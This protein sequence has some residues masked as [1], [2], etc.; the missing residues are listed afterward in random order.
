MMFAMKRSVLLIVAGISLMV[1]MNVNGQTVPANIKTPDAILQDFMNKRFGMF[2][3]WGPATLRGGDISWSRNREVAQTDYDSLYKEF[4]PVLFNADAWVK[5][6]SD[7]GMKYLTITAKHHDGFCLW[8]SKYTTH[9]IANTPYKKDIVKQLNDACK[10]Y[11]IKFCIYYTVLDWYDANYPLHNDG[12]KTPD[13]KADMGKFVQYMKN[14]LKELITS[15]HPYMLWFDGNWET[16]WTQDMAVD[17]YTY[18]KKLDAKVIINN[19]LGKATHKE[20]TPQTVGDYATPEQEIGKINMK[21]PW[22]SCIT[23][24]TQWS[25]KPND[26]MKSTAECIRIL[27]RTAGGNGNLLLNFSPMPDGRLEARQVERLEE[28]GSWMKKNGAA[29]YGTKGGPYKPDSLFSSTRK[30]NKIFLHLYANNN[31]QLEI[32]SVPGRKVMKTYFLNKGTVRYKEDAGKIILSWDGTM[33]DA[34]CSIIV[35]EL[36]QL[37]EDVPLI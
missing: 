21:D 11:G 6:A 35:V 34:A 14:Q 15:Y 5:A 28:I 32:P 20:M 22:E 17:I 23:I 3:H 27:S 19:R 10:K 36:D 31:G 1:S 12:N 4:D 29:I 24:G 7:A 16:P 8:P 30:G 33:P 13:P 9:T 2:I 18:I 25:W 37:V 26:K